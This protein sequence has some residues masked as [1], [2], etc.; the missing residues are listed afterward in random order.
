MRPA[1][2]SNGEKATTVVLT[3]ITTVLGLV[4]LAIGL[5]FNYLGLYTE[6]SPEF[7]WGG[8]QASWWGPMA[9]AVIS[10][11]LVSTALTLLIIPAVYSLLDRSR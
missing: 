10:G 9:I 6:L 7:Y 5:N 1:I 2:N 4:P 3:A 8:E 11:L